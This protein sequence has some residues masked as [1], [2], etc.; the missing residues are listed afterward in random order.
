VRGNV[1]PAWSVFASVVSPD[2]AVLVL[3]DGKVRTLISA[4]STGVNTDRWELRA[5]AIEPDAAGVDQR[6]EMSWK[7][8]AAFTRAPM[9]NRP[10]TVNGAYPSR[11][12]VFSMWVSGRFG[13]LSVKFAKREDIGDAE[14]EWLTAPL[15][16]TAA[17]ADL[18]Q[19][20][21]E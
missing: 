10:A 16:A 13:P 7:S 8:G 4:R 21:A 20:P 11:E 15:P 2:G 14:W 18:E 1:P 12:G 9:V 3:S 17:E 6:V 19:S 5:R